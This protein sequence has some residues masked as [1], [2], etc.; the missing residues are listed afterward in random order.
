MFKI[1]TIMMIPIFVFASS[2]E[3][4]TDIFWRTINF[5]IFAGIAYYILADKVKN[6]FVGRKNSIAKR[7]SDI[8]DKLK[9]SALKKEQAIAKVED[10]KVTAKSFMLTSEKENKLLI[11]KINNELNNEL[12]NLQKSQKDQME[13]E[14][15]KITR[16]VINE[17]LDELFDKN[18]SIDKNKFV[19]IVTKKVS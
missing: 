12:D 7:L 8:Q 4:E 2:E 17:V 18:I 10:A 9:E 19:D 14:R 11:D 3:A 1:L 6:Y 5:L 15:R 16:I 13:I